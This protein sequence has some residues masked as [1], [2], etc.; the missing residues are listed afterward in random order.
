MKS[1]KRVYSRVRNSSKVHKQEHILVVWTQ[2][3]KDII[4]GVF[5]L[6]TVD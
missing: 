6:R 3:E 1:Q 2:V 4:K 5:I